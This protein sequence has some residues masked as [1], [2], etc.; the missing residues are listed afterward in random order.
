MKSRGFDGPL[1]TDAHDLTAIAELIMDSIVSQGLVLQHGGT[2]ARPRRMKPKKKMIRVSERRRRKRIDDG[3]K[4]DED[5][6]E[7]NNKSDP[8]FHP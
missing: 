1:H 3:N 7:N 6:D 2:G 8:D 4:D 5:E